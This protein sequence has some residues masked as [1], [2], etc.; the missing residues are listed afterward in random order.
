MRKYVEWIVRLRWAVLIGTVAVT[1]FFAANLGKL[2]VIVDPDETLPQQHPFVQVTT[3]VEQLFGNKFS[4]VVGITPKQGDVFQP[5]VLAKVKA[6][7]TGLQN[8]PGVVKSNI[9]S[10][11]ARKAKDIKG[12]EAGLEVRPLMDA[13]PATPAQIEAVRAA[14]RA[15][16]AYA[17]SLVAKDERTTVVLAEFKKDPG[18][19][20]AIQSKVE[21]V[22]APHRDSTVEIAVVG[23]PAYLSLLEKYSERMAWLFPLAVLIIGLIHYEAFRT[24]QGLILPL[25][26]ALLAVVWGL[27]IMG[28]VN[29]PMDAFNVTTPILIFAV[30]AG[31]A[32]QIL[33]RYYEEYHRLSR[34]GTASASV[35][36]SLFT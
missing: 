12:T 5:G 29:V 9:F 16:P 4:V 11:S 6:I 2:E 15:N 32:V 28:L 23:G 25:V 7:T 14:F 3:K 27:G 17:N 22:V 13:V 26:T 35:T 19:F 36:R 10:L 33:K 1:A 30:A 24:L 8:T 21:Q 20:K 31:H 34:A 18:G